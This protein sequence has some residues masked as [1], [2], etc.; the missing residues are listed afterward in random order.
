M[1]DKLHVLIVEDDA[2]MA[3]LLVRKFSDAGFGVSHAKSGEDA[4]EQAGKNKP[5]I[6]SLDIMLPGIDGYE[7]L[8]R[9]KA[10]PNLS[11]IPVIVCSNIGNE[12]GM[13]RAKELGAIDY[14]V[15]ISIDFNDMIDR[16]K[17][18]CTAKV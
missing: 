13:S 3:D 9:L 6:I 1:S 5:D 4:L 16:F 2:F 8:K 17:R 12:E 14:L 10:D 11:K 7:V 15:K 18:T